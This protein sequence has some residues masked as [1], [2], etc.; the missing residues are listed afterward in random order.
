MTTQT[1]T[2]NF[3]VLIKSTLYKIF[4]VKE[5]VDNIRKE[6]TSLDKIILTYDASDDFKSK[7]GEFKNL[8]LGVLKE[9]H[10]SLIY[11]PTE[12]TI[13]FGIPTGT[14]KTWETELVNFF[15]NLPNNDGLY[16]SIAL[17]CGNNICDKPNYSL[18]ISIID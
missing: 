6:L 11:S 1:A 17:I 14:Y 8:I 7:N 4:K 10:V 5:E 12:S 9:N 13:I 2:N 18:S 15:S 3:R 16:Y